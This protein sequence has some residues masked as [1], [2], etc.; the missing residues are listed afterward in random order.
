MVR[1]KEKEEVVTLY[2]TLLEWKENKSN[3]NRRVYIPKRSKHGE[4]CTDINQ[5]QK[6]ARK[7]LK[8]E[9]RTTIH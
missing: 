7:K 1:A 4:Q 3:R 5:K 9:N 8:N 6:G 2:S